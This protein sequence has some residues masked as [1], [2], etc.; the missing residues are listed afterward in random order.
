M[1][2]CYLY[3][4]IA[5]TRLRYPNFSNRLHLALTLFGTIMDSIASSNRDPCTRSPVA[6]LHELTQSNTRA[7]YLGPLS[8]LVPL[9]MTA[10][11][12][13]EPSALIVGLSGTH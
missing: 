8:C 5:L 12:E 10:V 6:V 3:D 1:Y 4:G 7:H 2:I 13:G 11:L 9:A